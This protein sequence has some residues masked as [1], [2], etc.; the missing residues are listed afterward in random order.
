MPGT[1]RRF[2]PKYGSLY[3]PF[4]TSTAK[5]VFGAD[6]EYQPS[7]EKPTAETC[8]GGAEILAEDCTF[9]PSRKTEPASANKK[10]ERAAQKMKHANERRMKWGMECRRIR[11]KSRIR[12]PRL[13]FKPIEYSIKRWTGGPAPRSVAARREQH[14][15]NEGKEGRTLR[16]PSFSELRWIILWAAT[17]P[18]WRA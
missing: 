1:E 4:S 17:R 12:R 11:S 15:G 2:M 18:R 3:T 5:T 10:G 7:V 8:S 14:K 9:Q 16:A 13:R 6:V